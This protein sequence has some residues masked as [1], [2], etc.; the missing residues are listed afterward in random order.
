MVRTIDER[1]ASAADLPLIEDGGELRELPA[2]TRGWRSRPHPGA[3]EAGNT[4]LIRGA[5]Q[6]TADNV[7]FFKQPGQPRKLLIQFAERQNCR[8]LLG[9]SDALRTLV[10]AGL[11]ETRRCAVLADLVSLTRACTVFANSDGRI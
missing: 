7:V 11:R 10:L 9:S 1:H 3:R 6:N 5:F 8:V 4:R 2:A